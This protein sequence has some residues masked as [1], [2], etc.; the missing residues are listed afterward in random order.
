MIDNVLNFRVVR[1]ENRCVY[2]GCIGHDDFGQILEKKAREAGVNV[3]YQ[4]TEKAAT[5]T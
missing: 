4:Y 2:L 1:R 5:G 3:R